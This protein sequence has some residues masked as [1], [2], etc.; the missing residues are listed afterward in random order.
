MT[1][2]VWANMVIPRPLGEQ[3]SDLLTNAQHLEF[4]RFPNLDKSMLAR[5]Y[6]LDETDLTVMMTH[7]RDFNC[8][9]YAVQLTVGAALCCCEP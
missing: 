2:G 7:R 1:G 5:H 4:P 8:L 6:F 9:R 3:G